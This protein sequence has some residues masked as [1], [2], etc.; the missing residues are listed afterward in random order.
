MDG[1]RRAEI[2]TAAEVA[3]AD[4]LTGLG[5]DIVA[6]DVRL[7]SGQVDVVALDRGCL[8]I[9][10]VKARSSAAFGLPA[11]AV[12]WRKRRRLRRLAAE[13]RAIHLA[14]TRAFRVDVVAVDLDRAGRPSAF[15][16]IPAI[17]LDF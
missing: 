2:G 4:Y 8:V 16:H 6:L 7:P 5:F 1:H 3:A 15:R 9:V 10:E 14:G 17:D 12:D 11:E 13:Y